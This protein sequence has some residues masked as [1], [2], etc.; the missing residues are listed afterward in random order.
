MRHEHSKQGAA[1]LPFKTFVGT[2]VLKSWVLVMLIELEKG[3]QDSRLSLVR[4]GVG[5]NLFMLDFRNP[6]ALP[7]VPG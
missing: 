6:P 2:S 3:E 5:Y 1:D 4:C 7:I